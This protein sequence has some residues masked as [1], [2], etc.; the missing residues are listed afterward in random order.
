MEHSVHLGAGHFVEGVSPTS[1]S[2][3]IKKVQ[4]T[5]RQ[6]RVD[7]GDGDDHDGSDDDHQA[8]DDDGDGD[9]GDHDGNDDDGDNDGDDD[10]DDDDD[11]FDTGDAV[12]KA[13]GLIKQVNIFI[14]STTFLSKGFTIP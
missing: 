12:G 7:E 1:T 11:E 8:Q 14:L 3:V 2:T 10:D 9:D 4:N 5:S 13:L 6:A